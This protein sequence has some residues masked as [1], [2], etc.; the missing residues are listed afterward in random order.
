MTKTFKPLIVQSSVNSSKPMV[1]GGD[2]IYLTLEDPVT[3]KRTTLIDGSTGA[4]VGAVGH[5]D[6]EIIDAMKRAA[7]TS[8][9]NY[10]TATSNY[11]SENL[12]QFLIDNS[13]DGAF[14]G[15]L[16]TGSGS[17]S[18][19]NTL[20]LAKQFQDEIGQSQRFKFVSRRQAY[21][22]YTCGA[23]ALGDNP[24]R[25][26]FDKFLALDDIFLKTKAVY[27]YRQAEEGESLEQY[28]DRLVKD[29]EQV[30][31]D[32]DP[33][34]IV[35]WVGETVGGST[36]GTCPP[37]PG[38]LEGVREVCHKHGILFVL[39]EVMCGIGRCGTFHAWE[40]YLPKD[41]GPDLQTI[42]KTL[43]SGYV[44]IAAVLLSP[45]VKEG[46]SGGS[47]YIVGGQT[48]HLHAFNCSVALAVQEK[49]KRD[50]LVENIRQNGNYLGHQLRE[51]LLGK[52]KIVGDVRGVGGFWSIELVQNTATKEPFPA[53]KKFHAIVGNQI[54]KNGAASM[55][56]P[57]TVDNLKGDHVIFSPSF[58]ITKQQVDELVDIIVKSIHEVES[59]YTS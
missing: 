16:I 42:G 28:K 7:E 37:P 46:L 45:R 14:A 22:G 40:Q 43:G 57:G 53:E 13:P 50:G 15:A 5:G 54:S 34:S 10:P 36:F 29:V 39:D 11:P 31:I 52:S 56:C 51:K 47:G 3:K 1:V 24:R 4:S 41:K 49:V 48:Y 6:Y 35:A 21:H 59:E 9:Y 33:S 8:V 32:N 25:V 23:L 2:G 30:F 27:P 18:I 17:E 20:K 55:P 12:A 26:R 19:E 38:Y 44:T 58:I